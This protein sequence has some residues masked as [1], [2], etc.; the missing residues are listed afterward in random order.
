MFGEV[1]NSIFSSVSGSLVK[2]IGDIVEKY[3]PSTMDKA[4]LN[5]DLMN[6]KSDFDIKI[7]TLQN[8]LNKAYLADVDSARKMQIAALGQNDLFSKRFAYFLAIFIVFGAFLFDIALFFVNY[9]QAN[10]DMLNMVAGV[11]NTGAL[12]SVIN[13]FF[14]SSQGSV[15][16]Q[17]IIENSLNNGK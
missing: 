1:I 8:E 11:I 17:K 3:I 2:N 16:K 14:G 15:D 4:N 6:I 12:I 5:K 9:P 10:R 13:F 7:E